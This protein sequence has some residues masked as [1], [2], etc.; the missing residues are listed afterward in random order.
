[1]TDW[2]V[3]ALRGLTAAGSHGV[4]EFERQGSQDF[5]ADILLYVDVRR[6]AGSDNVEDTVDYSAVAEAAVEV[7]TGPSVCLI[8][9]LASRL[10]ELALS[11][12][13]VA[14]AQVTVHKPMAPL[15]LKF[16]DVSVTVVR[17]RKGLTSGS[18]KHSRRTSGSHQ[19]PQVVTS[20]VSDTPA[21]PASLP[22]GTSQGSKSANR[23]PADKGH[24]DRVPSD[25][26]PADRIPTGTKSPRKDAKL[27]PRQPA[28]S[29]PRE[30]SRSI[31]AQPS[32]SGKPKQGGGPG[33]APA[34]H[35]R[36]EA[37][38]RLR[39]TPARPQP[40][41]YDVVLAL[42]GNRGPVVETLRGAVEALGGLDGFEI[43]AV[44]SLVETVPVLEPGALPQD[45]Y[46]NAVV[47]GR[48][49][50]APPALLLAT[51]R[52]E[53]QFGRKRLGKWGARTLDIDIIDVDR[54]RLDNKLL[55]LP[56]PR[57][58]ERAFV[59]YP[60]RQVARDGYLPRHGA[61]A[62]LLP[63]TDDLG[64]V[65]AE[66]PEWLRHEGSD[67]GPRREL[68]LAP[69]PRS[70]V[71]LSPPGDESGRVSLRGVDVALSRVDDDPIFQR[72]LAKE[73]REAKRVP[74]KRAQTPPPSNVEVPRAPRFHTR[75]TSGAIPVRPQ[76][77][78]APDTPFSGVH[79]QARP[80][81]PEWD[82]QKR[83]TPVR[84]IDSMEDQSPTNV[85]QPELLQVN[86]DARGF[87]GGLDAGEA[88]AQMVPTL[89]W[90]PVVAAQTPRAV[91]RLARGV[92]VRPT[93]TGS[94]PLMRG[95]V[96]RSK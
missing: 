32:A 63:R 81:L 70:R 34:R 83:T 4:F 61:V 67:A 31:K 69:R 65:L 77:R 91:P 2:D 12:D 64:G 44:S 9:T 74:R 29:A 23:P 16:S 40:Y 35:G 52:I 73:E 90:E 28:G 8:E 38:P 79:R 75:P 21:R 42:G 62:D 46:L 47:L 27:T 14:K 3:I 82:F 49:V 36:G 60:W 24:A 37:A 66:Y 25:K 43:D 51:Q 89:K 1:M 30:D 10:A 33:A 87:S 94:V 78:P 48:T 6:A 11:Y 76:S 95:P 18:G 56:H 20:L 93:P 19:K 15:S 13:G 26:R 5:I 7:L 22:V 84:V 72:M 39:A 45:N 50:L 59:L 92:T 86:V 80:S 57:A 17:E 55:T 54:M 71:T 41:V 88:G 58:H 85:D 68:H 53:K 96:G